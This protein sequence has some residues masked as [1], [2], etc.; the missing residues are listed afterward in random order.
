MHAFA[1]HLD[2]PL[3]DDEELVAV[4]PSEISLLPATLLPSSIAPPF[5][6]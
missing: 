1:E 6:E 4:S 3:G 2:L 5:A